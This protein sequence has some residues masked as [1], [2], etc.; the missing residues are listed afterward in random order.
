MLLLLW[1]KA[2]SV[3]VSWEVFLCFRSC[4]HSKFPHSK[5]CNPLVCQIILLI[6]LCLVFTVLLS[7][8]LEALCKR[9]LHHYLHLYIS[10]SSWS[11]LFHKI[12]CRLFEDGSGRSYYCLP[13]SLLQPLHL[14]MHRKQP[15]AC[16]TPHSPTC[17]HW[18]GIRCV[19]L[20][21]GTGSFQQNFS[22]QS[23]FWRD[24]IS[25]SPKLPMPACHCNLSLLCG[26]YISLKPHLTSPL[27]HSVKPV[28]GASS[29]HPTN[30]IT[31]RRLM[32]I[33]G[34]VL[35]F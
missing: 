24:F 5:H 28:E 20:S 8:Y 34:P 1:A 7:A 16:S 26:C 32:A 9:C 11:L 21:C 23:V 18:W 6:I 25:L 19:R 27:I 14:I 33:D 15:S 2:N 13:Q 10:V 22:V 30:E 31:M 35:H 3:P 12:L 17:L 29:R 4:N